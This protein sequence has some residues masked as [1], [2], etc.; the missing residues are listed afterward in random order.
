VGELPVT[1]SAVRDEAVDVR[2]FELV[3]AGAEPLAPFQPG[4]HID[5]HIAPGLVRQYS[6]CNDAG[7]GRAAGIGSPVEAG[8]RRRLAIRRHRRSV[9][10]VVAQLLAGGGVLAGGDRRAPARAPRL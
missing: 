6:L 1:V 8:C 9:P 3:A 10:D 5:A 7:E 2:S 4:S